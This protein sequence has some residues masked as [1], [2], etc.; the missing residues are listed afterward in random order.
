MG[1]SVRAILI[2]RDGF[3]KCVDV[4]EK[5]PVISVPDGLDTVSIYEF[6]DPR[7]K[8]INLSI[9]EFRYEREYRDEF[10]NNV[11]IYKEM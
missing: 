8:E 4:R 9:R 3:R 6:G 2:R 1:T 5:T 11:L 10:D 7:A